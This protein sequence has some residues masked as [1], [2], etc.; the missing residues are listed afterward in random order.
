MLIRI[1]I[2]LK[3]QKE[4]LQNHMYLK[5]LGNC[6]ST[7]C[8]FKKSYCNKFILFHTLSSKRRESYNNK[9]ARSAF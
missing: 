4:T 9:F 5:S 2:P 7:S 1:K 8:I 3:I 6:A